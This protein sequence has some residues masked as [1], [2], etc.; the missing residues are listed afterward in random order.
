MMKA[1]PLSRSD[2]N[3]W[4]FR[5][6]AFSLQYL[7]A[8]SPFEDVLHCH[9]MSFKSCLLFPFSKTKGNTYLWQLTQAVFNATLLQTYFLA[10]RGGTGVAGCT[11]IW[12]GP[13]HW[14][15]QCGFFFFKSELAANIFKSRDFPQKFRC[16]ASLENSKDLATLDPHNS[17]IGAEGGSCHS[18]LHFPTLRP[19]EALPII[20][21]GL[22]L[23]LFFLFSV[24]GQLCSFTM[25]GWPCSPMCTEAREGHTLETNRLLFISWLHPLTM[26]NRQVMN[27]LW[28]RVSAWKWDWS[29]I[30]NTAHVFI[31][32]RMESTRSCGHIQW[33]AQ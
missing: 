30:H 11:F 19:L 23:F 8:L 5:N 10:A 2:L 33:D 31:W 25:P 16:L 12:F 14:P 9:L 20:T 29:S 7:K 6:L 22:L 32:D 15:K 1:V 28:A 26:G 17:R 3:R 4:D 27:S 13:E 21:L 24:S 18:P